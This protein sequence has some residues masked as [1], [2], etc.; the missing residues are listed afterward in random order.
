MFVSF[1][2]KRVALFVCA[3]LTVKASHIRIKGRLTGPSEKGL[4]ENKPI[5]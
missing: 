5:D 1:I 2:V 3:T 4:H